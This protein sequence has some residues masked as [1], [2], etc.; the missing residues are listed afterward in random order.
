MIDPASVSQLADKVAVL[1]ERLAGVEVWLRVITAMLGVLLLP[2]GKAVG[3]RLI[4]VK[5]QKND[6]E[7]RP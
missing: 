7:T 5:V 2:L 1:S 3:E 4:P 6:K